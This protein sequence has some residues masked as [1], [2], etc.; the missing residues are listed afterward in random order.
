[1]VAVSLLGTGRFIHGDV[2]DDDLTSRLLPVFEELN[3]LDAV[4]NNAA[5]QS[6]KSIVETLDADWD[7][8][9]RANTRSAFVVSRVAYP[10]LERTRG[11]IVNVAS[12]HSVATSRGLAAYAS[13][14]GALVAFTRSAALEFAS[15]GVRVNAVA[16]GAVDTPMLRQGLLRQATPENLDEAMQELARRTPLRRIGSPDE[17]AQAILFLADNDRSSFITGQTLV[18]DGGALAHLSTE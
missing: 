10:F 16:P 1:V 3:G 13:S 14:K 5:I 9:M 18:I 7:A 11:A 17:I 2:A 15:G 6:E 12:I 4:V 8:I